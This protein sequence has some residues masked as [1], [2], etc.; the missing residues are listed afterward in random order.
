MSFCVEINFHLSE[1]SH[2][3]GT[4]SS[5]SK[6]TSPVVRSLS[7][8]PSPFPSLQRPRTHKTD[9]HD[10]IGAQRRE[11]ECLKIY[12]T[13]HYT[14]KMFGGLTNVAASGNIRSTPCAT[15]RLDL[16]A[17][18]YGC[19][20]VHSLGIQERYWRRQQQGQRNTG[21]EIIMNETEIVRPE[22]NWNGSATHKK[23]FS[24]PS[25]CVRRCGSTE[26]RV[27]VCKLVT[28]VDCVLAIPPTP[29]TNACESIFHLLFCL[30][31]SAASIV[32]YAVASV[33][34]RTSRCRR[35]FE[36]GEIDLQHNERR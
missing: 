14:A 9:M 24:I 11:Y 18:R 22:R 15:H 1:R 33:C 31:C 36:I 3:I 25:H 17:V 21:W 16:V 35:L 26:M 10:I 8:F 23:R 2:L 6:S 27:C 4:V 29:H 5:K 28:F 13:S 7:L 32:R 20:R 30:S 12:Q 19:T 34:V